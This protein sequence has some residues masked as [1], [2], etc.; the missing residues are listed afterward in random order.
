MKAST[1]RILSLFG[2][3]ALFVASL[4]LYA[5]FIQPG[6]NEVSRMRGEL[7]AKSQ[8]F[9][10]QNAIITKV[11]DLLS[12]YQGIPKIQDTIA[13]ALPNDPSAAGI[14]AELQAIAGANNVPLQELALQ[15]L[16]AESSSGKNSGV[17]G[18]SR[19]RATG[20]VVGAYE[21]V[22]GFAS[23]VETNIRLMDVVELRLE[24]VAKLPGTLTANFIIDAYYQIDQ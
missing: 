24:P 23:G 6:Y 20:K 11:R 2:T 3:A 13:L 15:V 8:L 17:K 21:G 14:V 12:Q 18:L 9:A 10:E 22:K 1:K 16:P 7:A 19:V 5:S 4:L